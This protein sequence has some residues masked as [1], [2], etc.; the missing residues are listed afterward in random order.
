[1]LL[2]ISLLVGQ[3]HL[4]DAEQYLSQAQW[5][6]MQATPSAPPD[7]HSQLQRR[8]GLLAAARGE[9][10]AARRYFAEDVRC[11]LF[12]LAHACTASSHTQLQFLF[13]MQIYNSS[14]AHGPY[15][16]ETAGG[17]FHLASVFALENKPSVAVSLHHQVKKTYNQHKYDH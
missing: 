11:W 2:P 13:F 5:S 10:Q 4:R 7:L 8:L 9:L 6:I 15:A 14:V 3:K 12:S 16:I 17:F 1:M